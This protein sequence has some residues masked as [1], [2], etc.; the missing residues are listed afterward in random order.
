MARRSVYARLSTALGELDDAAFAALLPPASRNSWAPAH[1]VTVDGE[2]VFI[3]RVPVTEV[4]R[5]RWPSTRNHHRVPTFYQYGIGSFG[6]NAVRELQ[7]HIATTQWVLDGEATGFPLLLHHRIV[8]RAVKPERPAAERERHVHYWADSAAIAERTNDQ[9]QAD[10]ELCLVLEYIPHPI[11]EWLPDHQVGTGTVIGQL[12][13]CI[14]QLH[15]HGF[16][17]FDAHLGNV[18]TDGEQAYLTDFGLVLGTD[19]ELT[20]EERKFLARH[21]HYDYGA[22]LFSLGTIEP[23][24][25]ARE[26][27]YLAVVERYEGAIGYMRGF[28]DRLSND[29]QK[30]TWYDDAALAEFLASAN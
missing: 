18:L 5:L 8:P 12:Q 23:L 26:P 20:A 1:P 13:R 11:H 30:Q 2:R 24:L 28:Y 16:V 7:A 15:A 29:P 6:V 19:F 14:E 9:V 22:L 3:K 10:D 25:T 17:H 21:A 4:E 27:G